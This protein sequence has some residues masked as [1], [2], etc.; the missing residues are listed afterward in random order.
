MNPTDKPLN[1]FEP[2]QID[3]LDSRTIEWENSDASVRASQVI[4]FALCAGVFTYAVYVLI[5][6]G[7]PRLNL[8]LT[9][10]NIISAFVATSAIAASFAIPTVISGLSANRL[11]GSSE[12]TSEITK[13]LFAIFQMQL[14]LGAAFLEG[15]SF[16]NVFL[17]QA[18]RG[19][20]PLTGFIVCAA[21]LLL[22]FP[23]KW[24]VQ[25]WIASRMPPSA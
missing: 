14:I 18:T 17:Y 20:I 1:P 10:T 15:A 9:P 23:T 6:T 8:W 25:T 12:P 24:R 13:K 7:A 3:P 2:S 19:Y 11:R 16:L 21:L 5:Q 22:R 4:I